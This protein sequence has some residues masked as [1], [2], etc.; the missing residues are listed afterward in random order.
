MILENFSGAHAIEAGDDHLQYMDSVIGDPAELQELTNECVSDVHNLTVA[1]ARFEHRC[2]VESA[3]SELLNEGIAEFFAKVKAKIVE[4]WNKFK[5]WVI[6][7]VQ[8]IRGT[9][10]GPRKKWLDDKRTELSTASFKKDVKVGIYSLMKSDSPGLLINAMETASKKA[11]EASTKYGKKGFKTIEEVK[12]AV[13]DS[14]IKGKKKSESTMAYLE[15]AYLGKEVEV[16]IDG[17]LVKNLINIADATFKAADALPGM[18]KIADGMIQ[19]G[20]ALLT[21]GAND[22]QE[23]KGEKHRYAEALNAIGPIVSQGVSAVIALNSKY[24][25][26]AMSA[27]ATAYSNRAGTS[28]KNEGGS[29]LD[30][31]VS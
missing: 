6:N 13:E 1:L 23:E 21:P 28:L 5:A 29:L 11:A 2:I 14:L 19:V 16:K 3:G 26:K 27:L 15:R 22:S 30:A 24:N 18:Q 7:L 10:F 12:T 31:Y 8:K 20:N 4:Y 17:A 25:A 9:V